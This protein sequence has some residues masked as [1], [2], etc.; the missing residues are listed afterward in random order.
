MVFENHVAFIR[1]SKGVKDCGARFN[2]N[3]WPG[4]LYGI[5]KLYFNCLLAALGESNSKFISDLPSNCLPG[6][7]R[8]LPSLLPIIYFSDLSYLLDESLIFMG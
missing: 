8:N 3:I 1:S 2:D 6:L 5:L 7:P 4:L